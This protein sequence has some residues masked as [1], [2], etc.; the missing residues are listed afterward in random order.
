MITKR[1]KSL[2]ASAKSDA[3]LADGLVALS[4]AVFLDM[5]LAISTYITVQDEQ[6]AALEAE[7]DAAATR[8]AAAVRAVGEDLA[9]LAPFLEAATSAAYT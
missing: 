7:R 5:E 4:K 1:A 8:Q 2:F 6:R 9:Q 3:D